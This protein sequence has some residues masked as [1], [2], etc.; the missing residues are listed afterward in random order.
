MYYYIATWNCEMIET[1]EEWQAKIDRAGL[2]AASA[3]ASATTAWAELHGDEH[4]FVTWAGRGI[5]EYLEHL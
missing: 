4:Q 2:H 3:A 5:V 1:R